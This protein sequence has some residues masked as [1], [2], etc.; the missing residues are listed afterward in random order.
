MLYR[1]VLFFL[2]LTV[3]ADSFSQD[4]DCITQLNYAIQK[5]ETNYAGYADKVTALTRIRY[6]ELNGFYRY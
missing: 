6:D 1:V 5:I 4:C 3:M 2:L